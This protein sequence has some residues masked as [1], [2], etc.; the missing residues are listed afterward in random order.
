MN[1]SSLHALKLVFGL[2]LG[3]ITTDT[4]LAGEINMNA[5]DYASQL[6][7]NFASDVFIYRSGD[8]CYN[9]MV[10]VIEAR[11]WGAS[12]RYQLLDQSIA[13]LDEFN[14]ILDLRNTSCLEALAW[15]PRDKHAE[16]F[17]A[18]LYGE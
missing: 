4:K 17:K 12:M 15:I 16:L 1:L 8:K 7:S 2:N 13:E 6:V 9:E 14:Q 3:E 11:Q 10:T 5:Q 18:T